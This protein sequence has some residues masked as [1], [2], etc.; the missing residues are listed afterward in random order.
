MGQNNKNPS[1]I[2]QTRY[3]VIETS[4]VRIHQQHMI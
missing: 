2:G 3:L 4:V 1:K